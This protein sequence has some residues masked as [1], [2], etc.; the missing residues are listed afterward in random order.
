MIVLGTLVLFSL[1]E[2]DNSIDVVV[3]TYGENIY[4]YSFDADTREFLAKGKAHAE[5]ASYALSDGNGNIYASA[6]TKSDG[7]GVYK[8]VLYA[9]DF[10]NGL[11]A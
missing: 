6:F 9:K 10:I 5:N 11:P 8:G 2:K 1:L 3:G 4:M 7:L